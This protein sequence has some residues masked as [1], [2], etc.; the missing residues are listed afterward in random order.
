MERSNHRYL[1]FDFMLKRIS[2][3]TLRLYYLVTVKSD[4]MISIVHDPNFDVNAKLSAD[5][6]P[7]R[8]H[9]IVSPDNMNYFKVVWNNDGQY[10]STENGCANNA[11][12]SFGNDCLCTVEVT[13]APV[14]TAMPTRSQILS[15]AHIGHL[16]PDTYDDDIYTSGL[17]SDEIEVHVKSG[18]DT[19]STHSIFGT[20]YRGKKSYFRNL[21]SNV[22]IAGNTGDVVYGFRNPPQ[23]LNIGKPD[24]RDA[25]YET[26]AVIDHY[27]YH[28]NTAPYLAT[29]LIKRFGISNPSLRYVKTVATAFTNGE[30]VFQNAIT[31]G[32]GKYGNLEAVAAAIVMD[33]E[34]RSVV[35]D[36]DPTAGSLREPLIKIISFMRAM[37]YSRGPNIK[38]VMLPRLQ[39][40]V[41]QDIHATPTVFS[42]FF[43]DFSP[44]GKVSEAGL[45]APEAQVLDS[46]KIVGMMN[47]LYS[48]VDIGLS[49]CF[50]GFGDR[51][52]WWCSN[53]LNYTPEQMRS[54]GFLSFTPKNSTEGKAVV[55]ELSLLLTGSRLNSAS[56]ATL[57][58]AYNEE[59]QYGE[60]R[61]LKLV[62]KLIVSTP[63]FHST[64]VFESINRD[65]QEVPV[66]EASSTPYKAI[67]YVNLDG[68]LDSFNMLVP[69]SGCK[70]DTGKKVMYSSK[71]VHIRIVM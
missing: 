56:K 4:G 54:R 51:N 39:E 32:D 6:T 66:P 7:Q 22:K 11:C 1:W 36:T 59:L 35:L 47:G 3:H 49:N 8:V 9:Q 26:E 58:N 46:P 45:T 14:F 2:A 29:Q 62:Q 53:Y 52:T 30:Y 13:D 57:V 31:F 37:E 68:G 69:H 70:G 42:F 24:T 12:Q 21:V 23:F 15:H 17:S 38:S 27:F 65:R 61:A 40:Q 55:N 67:V 41:G 18:E 44:P 19:F 25:I 33:R 43:P 10:P 63:E 60:E 5:K 28:S 16:H 34:M 48:L 71:Q 50:G 64:N 20:M